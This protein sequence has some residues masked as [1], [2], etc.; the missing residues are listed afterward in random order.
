MQEQIYITR[1]GQRWGPYTRE[2]CVE[3]LG[4]GQLV[5]MDMAWRQ[6]MPDWRP[7]GE[8]LPINFQPP[9]PIVPVQAHQVPVRQSVV[10]QVSTAPDES[11]AAIVGKMGCGCLLWI[12]LLAL[13]IGGGVIFP[14]LLILLPVAFIGGMIDMIKKLSQLSKR[15]QQ[16]RQF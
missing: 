10:S 3:M 4:A 2:Q 5:P 13:A 8:V 11:A 14:V 9:A 7:L 1:S 6:G 16:N 15:R 12:G